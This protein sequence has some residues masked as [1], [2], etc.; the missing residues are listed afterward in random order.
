MRHV[1]F[2]RNRSLQELYQDEEQPVEFLR[3]SEHFLLLRLYT[4]A[5]LKLEDSLRCLDL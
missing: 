1:L 3:M 5:P 2:L 4:S